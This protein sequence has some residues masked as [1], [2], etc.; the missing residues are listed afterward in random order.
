MSVLTTKKQPNQQLSAQVAA[1]GSM[2]VAMIL[3]L[4]I[5]GVAGAYF[6]ALYLIAH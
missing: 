1:Q 2:R 5:L 6:A 3:S 4:S